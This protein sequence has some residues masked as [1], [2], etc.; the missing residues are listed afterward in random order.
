MIAES[1]NPNRKGFHDRPIPGMD[2][3]NLA[4]GALLYIFSQVAMS[5]EKS[6]KQSKY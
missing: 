5:S 2:G 6:W 3:K 1:N 4:C